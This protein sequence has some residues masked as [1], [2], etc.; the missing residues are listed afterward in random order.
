[1]RKTLPALLLLLAGALAGGLLQGC[2][3]EGPRL[4]ERTVAP[5]LGLVRVGDELV[6]TTRGAGLLRIPVKGGRAAAVGEK[7]GLVGGLIEVRAAIPWGDGLC[8][9]TGDGVALF[10]LKYGKVT[11]VWRKADGLVGPPNIRHV[12]EHRGTLWAGT[13]FGASRL[14]PGGKRWR[15][16]DTSSGLQQRHVYRLASDGTNLWAS[17]MGGGLARYSPATDR[18]VPVPQE[19]GLGNRSIYAIVF[20]GDEMWLGTAG[21][22]NLYR[23]SKG[24]WDEAVCSNGFTDLTVYAIQPDGGRLWYGTSYGLVR[25]AIDGGTEVT[26]RAGQGLPADEI[27][28]LLKD[29]DTLWIGTRAGVS[30]VKLKP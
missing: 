30:R 13:I 24:E 11:K 29:G 15:N 17:C 23:P 21:G 20:S 19:R 8:L 10:S 5:V 1:V 27:S 28:V 25:R 26:W 7:E 12:I 9:A 16:Y 2:G 22:V 6:A 3:G 18:W 14:L 4:V